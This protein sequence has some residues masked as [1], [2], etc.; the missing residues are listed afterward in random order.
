VS[1]NL[2]IGIGSVA[3]FAVTGQI[4]TAGSVIIVKAIAGAAIRPWFS[5]V[6]T[7][8]EF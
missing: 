5:V 4:H 7:I 3:A 6:E 8:D 1:E 2:P